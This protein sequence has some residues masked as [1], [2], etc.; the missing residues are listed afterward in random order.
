[1]AKNIVTGIDIGTY[2]IKVVIADGDTRNEKG[3]PKVI[4][5]A[6]A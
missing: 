5:A 3:F 4:G 6:M 2:H 1:M